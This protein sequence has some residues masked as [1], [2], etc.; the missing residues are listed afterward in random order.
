MNN[1]V[2][3][4]PNSSTYY[5]AYVYPYVEAA[6]TS[7]YRRWRQ[8]IILEAISIAI[9]GEVPFKPK[10][11]FQGLNIVLCL[12]VLL[13]PINCCWWILLFSVCSEISSRTIKIKNNIHTNFKTDRHVESMNTMG[14]DED[15]RASYLA[16]VGWSGINLGNFFESMPFNGHAV[17][18]RL[19][20]C[21]ISHVSLR[22]WV[23]NCRPIW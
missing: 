9:L 3:S 17:H 5:Q 2:P 14:S 4:T 13:V 7:C 11:R 12:F 1:E 10:R 23:C 18:G 16:I 20:C 6:N 21:R 8:K 22:K 15:G 19:L